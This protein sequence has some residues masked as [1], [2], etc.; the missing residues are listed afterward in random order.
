MILWL[1]ALHLIFMVCWFA[2]LFYLPRLFVYHANIAVNDAA[3]Y[4]R[5]CLMERKLFWGIT[6]PCAL[7]TLLFGVGLLHALHY[8][9][10][11]LPTW[12]F[13]KLILIATLIVY[14]LYCG[15]FLSRFKS[16][17]NTHSSTFYR[18]F[19]EYTILVLFGVI[20]LAVLKPHF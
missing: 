16:K 18:W 10:S 12:L 15:V 13:W 9:F 6:T 5:F 1:K 7:F 14:H 8:S 17:T 3:S 20:L 2:G 4:D 19:N 11:A